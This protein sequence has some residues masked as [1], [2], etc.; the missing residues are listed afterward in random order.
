MRF[1]E[2][3]REARARTARLLMAF[4]LTVAL[5]VVAVNGALALV[6]W[7]LGG[8]ALAGGAL[9]PH[10][11][12]VNTGVVLLYVLGGWWLETG[13]L[14]EGGAVRLAEA[15]GA[16]ALRPSGEAAEQRFANIV[17]EMAIA[18]TLPRPVPMVLARHGGINAFATG[19]D[20]SDAVVAVSQGALDHLTR[21]ELQ[22]V[23]AHELSHLGEGDTRLALRLAGMVFGLELIFRLGQ[24]LLQ[25]DEHGRRGLSAA[26]GLALLAAGYPG[27]V[28]GHALQAAVSRQREYL[29]D[30]RAVQWTRSRDGLGGVLRKVL[31]QRQQGVAPEPAIASPVQHLLLV[32][33]EAGRA[34]RWF[35]PHPPLTERIRR[36]YGRTL[37]PLPL[38]PTP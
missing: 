6:W 34:A 33:T 3:Q 37:G 18:A 5:L 32:G 4:A 17:D 23:V 35:D 36:I 15:M 11:L 20:P 30:A 8:L 29:A 16:R 14:R 26:I 19:W 9:P 1:F 22:A 27:W 13:R 38:A 24:D 21:E 2:A 12:A 31:A 28:A 25:A 10:F 7:M